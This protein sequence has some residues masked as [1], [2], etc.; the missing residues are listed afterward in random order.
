MT[1][2]FRGRNECSKILIFYYWPQWNP[3]EQ[4]GSTAV[5]L[6]SL[7]LSFEA[8]TDSL[9]CHFYAC[10]A[11]LWWNCLVVSLLA[12]C[13][14]PWSSGLH[15]KVSYSSHGHAGPLALLGL[16]LSQWHV[17]ICKDILGLLPSHQLIYT[18][19]L[20]DMNPYIR[21]EED[22]GEHIVNIYFS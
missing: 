1:Q 7:C 14:L 19:I 2:R 15:Y 10:A 3:L 20:T 21:K 18:S 9:C 5:P 13:G 22:S 12:S 4:Q 16:S 11:G 8:K 17:L 6:T